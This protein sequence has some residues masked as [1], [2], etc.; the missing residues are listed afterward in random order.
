LP[1]DHQRIGIG[2]IENVA[3]LPGYRG[4]GLAGR[5][6]EAAVD[7]GRAAGFDEAHI[8][9]LIGNDPMQ[10]ELVET[11][12]TL[13]GAMM[14]GLRM[15]PPREAMARARRSWPSTVQVC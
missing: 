2:T 3:A 7:K 15:S 11:G 4:Q 14:S 12:G 5:L 8:T 10:V 9:F 1:E 6:I 13:P